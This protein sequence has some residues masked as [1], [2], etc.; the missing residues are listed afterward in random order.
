MFFP[1]NLYFHCIKLNMNIV[2][3]FRI[4]PPLAQEM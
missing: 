3:R 2:K 4:S 1:G